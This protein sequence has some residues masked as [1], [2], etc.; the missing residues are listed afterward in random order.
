MFRYFLEFTALL[1]VIAYC[2][3]AISSYDCY[4]CT[5]TMNP[6]L[7]YYECVTSPADYPLGNPIGQCDTPCY[8]LRQVELSSGNIY[9]MRRGCRTASDPVDNTCTTDTYY[10]Y[11]SS[12]CESNLC[13]AEDMSVK[14]TPSLPPLSST[15]TATPTTTTEIPGT[16]WCYSCVYSYNPGA[17][18]R[19]I[20]DPP[21]APPGPA[22]VRCPPSRYCTITRQY[23]LAEKVVR[24]FRRGCDPMSTPSGCVTDTY[25]E[26]CTSY[27][28]PELCN[29]GDGTN[30]A[31]KL[32]Q[33]P[34]SES[35]MQL[36]S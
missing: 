26:T 5:Y 19:C 4:I 9:L 27:C 15:S 1:V 21:N 28:M 17:D 33:P 35:E 10:E 16:R 25:F 29:S 34:K 36:V 18:D 6:S 3:R 7:L 30:P 31:T 32:L 20:T 23:D 8:S 22:Q 2:P 12:S 11:C 14:T 24:S 13:N